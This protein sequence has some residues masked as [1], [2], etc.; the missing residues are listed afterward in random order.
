MTSAHLKTSPTV[1][2]PTDHHVNYNKIGDSLSIECKA[3]GVPPPEITWTKKE[4]IVSTGPVLNITKLEKHHE[5]SYTCLAA[6]VEGKATSQFELKFSKAPIFDFVPTNKTVIEGSNVFW[7]C[8]ADTQPNGIQYTWIFRDR[9]IKT[10]ETGLRVEI[11]EGD[12]SLRA[13]R[14]SDRGWY[15]CKAHSPSGEQS[16]V[17]AFLDVL[18]APEPL[19]SHRPVLTIG[20]GQNGTISCAMDGNPKPTHYTW[21][22]NGHFI[23]TT[24]EESLTIRTAK[25]S[26]GGIF[27]CQAENSIGRSTVLET[28]VI[29]AEPPVFITRPPPELRVFEGAPA[30]VVCDGFGDPLPIVYWVHSEKRISSSV[31]SFP[32]VSHS[33]HGVYECIISNAVSSISS[34]MNL[35]VDR[36]RPQSAI[37]DSVECIGDEAMMVNWTPGFN[38]SYLQSFV[39][40]YSSDDDPTEKSLLTTSHSA[41]IGDLKAFSKYRIHVESRNQKGSTNSS[42]VEKHVCST[43]PS[44]LNIRFSG[45]SELR[46]DPVEVAKSYRVESR[47]D[48][49]SAF[50]GIGEVFDPLFRMRPQFRQGQSFRVRSL[51]DAYEP[52][53]PSRTITYGSTGYGPPSMWWAVFGGVLFFFIFLFLYMY[54][55]YGKYI[56]RQRKKDMRYNDYVCPSS[57]QPHSETMYAASMNPTESTKSAHWHNSKDESLIGDNS[58][59]ML[60]YCYVE[61][62]NSAVD[63]ML[64]DKY[65]YGAEDV[66]VQLMND[67]RI[68]KLRRE[69]KQS[70]L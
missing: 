36:T 10:T 29:I 13:V 17:S 56:T 15:V 20:Y 49:M 34:A 23:S 60:E 26:D 5:G 47:N 35:I 32:S 68:E 22:K 61:E 44:P 19:P 42:A 57:F 27:G 70:Q 1:T 6:N 33:D 45:E 67:L 21:S 48:K 64:R 54:S 59:V 24:S 25:D 37:I 12:L 43:L 38:G 53:L 3:D 9:P 40:H 30:N 8:H 18:Y 7:R 16:K 63:D 14:K 2:S 52:S 55:R 11:K 58:Q 31:L 50:E 69:F 62:S 39:V 4:K 41:T 65:L 46:W 51:R 66:P 28:H